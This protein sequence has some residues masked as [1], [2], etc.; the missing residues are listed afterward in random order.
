MSIVERLPGFT[1]IK[2]N[3]KTCSICGNI[4]EGRNAL[5]YPYNGSLNQLE[6]QYPS[7]DTITRCAVMNVGTVK[8]FADIIVLEGGKNEVAIDLLTTKISSII[9]TN[10]L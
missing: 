6:T 1:D 9:Q 10:M 7:L 5:I 2:N 3:I 8:K 4:T